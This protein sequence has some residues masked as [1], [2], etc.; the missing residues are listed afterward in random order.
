[1]EQTPATNPDPVDPEPDSAPAAYPTWMDYLLVFVG[2]VVALLL[3]EMSGLEA[4]RT[5]KTPNWF[6]TA[7]VRALPFMVML[8]VGVIL[9]WPLFFAL[10]R[11]RG[12]SKDLS[13]V[14]WIWG[15]VWIVDL[16]AVATLLGFAIT[17]S[18]PVGLDEVKNNLTV[19]VKAVTSLLAIMAICYVILARYWK[20]DRAKPWTHHFALALLLWPLLPLFLLWIGNVVIRFR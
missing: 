14:E 1:M 4:L 3:V 17:T 2:I 6:A 15:G 5:T 20:I 18:N 11:F 12:R 10:S 7:L 13:I 9:F 16:A 8:P 19:W